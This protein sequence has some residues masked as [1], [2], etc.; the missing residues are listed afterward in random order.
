M[1]NKDVACGIAWVL[2]VT[3]LSALILLMSYAG[4]KV[5]AV[6]L[7]SPESVLESYKSNPY[8]RFYE[9]NEGIAWTT[10]HPDGY[11]IN[12]CGV[13]TYGGGISIYRGSDGTT[14]IPEGTVSRKELAGP[15]PAGHHYYAEPLENTVIPVGRWE[16]SQSEARCIHG[17]FS[18]CRDFE[19]YGINGLS[20]VKCHERYDSGWIAYCADCGEQITGLVYTNDDCISRIGY[21]YAG[22]DEF[23]KR[24]PAEYLFVCPICGDNLENDLHMVSHECKCFVSANRY[25][26]AYDGNGATRG[27]MEKSV[28]YYG[29]A[30]VYEGTPVTGDKNLRENEYVRPG[31]VFVGW[32]D[33]PEG[34]ILFTD[35]S[36][37]GS[38]ESYYTYLSDT[39]D[40]A[41]DREIK[42]YAVWVRSDCTI[43]ISG[44]SFE[45]SQG[46]YNGIVNGYFE[47]GR[48]SFTKGC[49]YETI[50]DPAL[51]TAPKGYRIE[52]V[53][54]GGAP[55]QDIYA[56]SELIGW[57]FDSGDASAHEFSYTEGN[58]QYRGKVSGEISNPAS[59][60]SFT[61]IHSSGVSGNADNAHAL[62]KSTSVI[63]PEA[64]YPGGIFEGWF[65]D[66]GYAPDTYV[67]KGGDI[68]IPESDKVL[69]AGFSG[70]GL[71]ATPDYMGNSDFGALRYSGLTDLG[72][73]RAT[74][75]DIYKYFI[76]TDYPVCNWTEA[77]TDDRGTY[78]TD[79]VRTFSG[80]GKYTEYK[81]PVSGIYSFEL[82]GGAGAS[83]DKY[84][85]ENGEYS[86]CRIFLNKGDIV[87]I[88]T[89]SAGSVTSGSGGTNCYGGE[90]SYISVNGNIVMSSSGG[91][92]A[93]FILNVRKE[94][95]Y[96]GY[97][98]NFIA[99]SE[100]DYTLQV[101]GAEGNATTAGRDMAGR[102]G[103]ATGHIPLKQGDVL[104]ICV[105]GR[106][107]YNG[108]GP[109]GYDG[110]WGHGGNGGGATHIASRDGILRNL[111]YS[112]NS[113]YIVAGGG[114][115]AAGSMATSGAGGGTAGGNGISPWPDGECIAGGGT[116]NA[117][118]TT[119][120]EGVTVGG[121]G[122][123]GAGI[124]YEPDSNISSAVDNGGGGGGWYG[125][126][127]GDATR[128][129]Y[130]CG[131]GG[132]SGY[133][134][135]VLDGSMLIGM[136]S[137]NG[138]AVI[139]CSVNIAGMPASGLGTSFTPG[140]LL[141]SDHTVKSHSGCIYPSADPSK[142]GYCIITEPSSVYL[143]SSACKILSPDMASP[144]PVSGVNLHYDAMIG[145]ADISW[146]MPDDNGTD[147]YYMA[148]AYRS[149][150][151]FAGITDKYASTEI[152]N[153]NI[154]TGVYAY[155][156][157]IDS[158]PVRNDIYVRNYG[159]G[160]LTAWSAI[161]GSSPGAL[162]SEWYGRASYADK[163]TVIKYLPTGDDRYIHIIAVDRAGN[164]SPVLNASVDGEGAFI[165]YP[166]VTEDISMILSDNVCEAEG[167]K[168]TYYVK[169]DG[170]TAFSLE[171]GAYINGFARSTY[172]IDKACIHLSGSE[173]ARFSFARNANVA[174][175]MYMPA[176]EFSICG[177]FPFQIA[178]VSDAA[179]TNRSSRLTFTGT[180]TTMSE[181]EMYLYPTAHA[182]LE[183]G[184]EAYGLDD[185][186]VSSER[187]NDLG[188]G[189]TVIGDGTAPECMVSVNGAEYEKLSLCDIT[190]IGSGHVV[191]RRYEDVNI[192]LYVTD[193]GS[194]LRG[195]FEVY[196]INLDN[197]MEGRFASSGEHCY[198]QLK[199]DPDCE[200]PSFDNKLFNGK[201]VIRVCSEDNV[202]NR[203]TEESAGL[204][205][206][207]VSGEI[208]RTLDTVTGP[209][210]DDEGRHYI[211]R[212]E[213]G[214]VISRVW[215]YPDAVLVSF[216]DESLREYDVLYV[217]GNTV[218][219]ALS[220]YAGRVVYA[221]YSDYLYETGTDFM[222]PLDYEGDS[223][224]VTITGYKAGD[225][226]TWN[227]EC[228]VISSGTVLDELMTVLR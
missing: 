220:D 89:G 189:I 96:T 19:Y 91:K 41:N 23:R 144:N 14:V 163:K 58:L 148:R 20:N 97:V 59:D 181:D 192:D 198:L 113:I 69:Y 182:L 188:H 176:D 177:P 60:G 46:S 33:S 133:T 212:G 183:A 146:D 157:V 10:I 119:V 93:S 47:P 117:G 223:V 205:E 8:I 65:T 149:R 141:Y 25:T 143:S 9:G 168:R 180:F 222:I 210:I 135:G 64:V 99:E 110:Y 138:Y 134:G 211:K 38:I 179:R 72:I 94:Y 165:P 107:G 187:I 172:Q 52:L 185:G 75:Y 39:G 145:Y 61:Y 44:G 196:V 68:F 105:G 95:D 77:M 226:V 109:G 160:I 12:G 76:S 218:P 126:A 137:G 26:I 81:A 227:A 84:S 202:G 32:S 53:V 54:P 174:E 114:G 127:G 190:N 37:T 102:G 21:I 169:A 85:G 36:S 125:G 193:S 43:T 228:E 213:S 45:S 17:P 55:M 57:E 2:V 162:F 175:D 201:I 217:T 197:G 66:P 203:G 22:D 142:A 86:S 13:Y 164:V 150:D 184:Y 130:G 219:G 79:T 31:Y 11:S 6:E 128:K 90:G 35:G 48:N 42:L 191:D 78:G 7:P 116:E 200:E 112:R 221:G 214:Y 167:R 140:S 70:L 216:A 16:I 129:S 15:L 209:L 98:Q 80:G 122:Y 115:G 225:A 28:C 88:Y 170:I 147:Y 49:M 30:D 120:S 153:L 206:L 82:W 124:S 166:V 161:S 199:Q 74:E 87:G 51:L 40:D 4:D 118:G 158:S 132:G 50:I 178:G 208:V 56:S 154:K 100:G 34:Q 121:F 173:Y 5:S 152:E 136:R 131:G 151:V 104:Y 73:A 92:G 71:S 155:Y 62:W 111:S 83:Y 171:Y 103:Y 195:N 194:G 156:Y 63:L 123:G 204:I 159:T 215:G 3:I 186:Y 29:G 24:Y 27:G 1:K 224:K 18:A 139:T 101:W 108:G 67:G 106:D 207:D